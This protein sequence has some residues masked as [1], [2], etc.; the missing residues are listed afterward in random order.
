[1][2]RLFST[3]C[4]IILSL[5][6]YAKPDS[7]P[8]V[9]SMTPNLTEI[10]CEL[11]RGNCLVGR[12]DACDYP[13]S[14]QKLPTAGKFGIPNTEQILKLKPD[15]IITSAL[16]DKT[17]IK[18]YKA[19]GIKIYFLP[20]D[21][22]EDYFTA[23][24][25]LGEILDCRQKASELTATTRKKLRALK[26][27]AEKTPLA[28]R[29]KILLALHD[30]PLMTIGRKSYINDIIN[31]AGGVNIAAKFNRSYFNCSLEWVVMRQPDILILPGQKAQKVNEIMKQPGWRSIKAV[32][33][34]QVYYNLDPDLIY[35]L[36][37]RTISGIEQIKA[38]IDNRKKQ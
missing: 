38:I 28:Q 27:Q 37:P 4:L 30:S 21:K 14:V 9:V 26:I 16:K 15:L 17:E 18:K 23:V 10:I 19:Y 13:A 1:M 11:G 36:G 22:L 34:K 35:R 3:I 5:T 32:T 20:Y 31:Y 2:K 6:G 12:S 24:K 33:N 8:R 7:L 29:P 25:K